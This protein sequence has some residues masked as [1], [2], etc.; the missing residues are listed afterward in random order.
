MCGRSCQMDGIG[1][2]Q[3]ASWVVQLV[4]YRQRDLEEV[5]LAVWYKVKKMTKYQLYTY[6]RSSCSARVRIAANHKG[7]PLDFVFVNLLKGEQKSDEYSEVNTSQSLPTLLVTAENGE[8]ISI[9]QSVA[10][11]EFLEETRPELS[12]LLPSNSKD[13]AFV[14]Q[15]VQIVACDIQPV[16]NLKVLSRVRQA[17]ID[18]E[19]WQR[20]FMAAG[21]RA[22]E[23]TAVR[24]GHGKFSI[25]DAITMAD[26]VLAPA[27]DGAL[28]FN[29]DMDEFPRVKQIYEAT[30]QLPAFRAGS[31]RSQPDTPEQFREM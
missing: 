31:W 15:L 14:R 5:E 22:Y 8:T 25:G 10:I 12:P 13:R 29:V 27:V 1:R 26:V 2:K 30:Q 7:I 18:G 21:L 17:G 16:T 24:Y 19:E 4:Q 23:K 11:L 28:R 3:S 6:F 20:D 9:E